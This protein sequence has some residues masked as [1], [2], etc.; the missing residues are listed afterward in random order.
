ML[1]DAEKIDRDLI[2]RWGYLVHALIAAA[3]YGVRLASTL[4]ADVNGIDHD[5]ARDVA[6]RHRRVHD[7]GPEQRVVA[8]AGGNRTPNLLNRSQSATN[9]VLDPNR[10]GRRQARSRKVSA[11][12]FSHRQHSVPTSDER[13]VDASSGGA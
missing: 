7:G 12:R 5:E 4:L 13:R 1:E 11:V 8:L 10:A 6:C 9:A 3:A 2:L